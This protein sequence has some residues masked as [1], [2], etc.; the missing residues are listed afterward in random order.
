MYKYL[1]MVRLGGNLVKTALFADSPLHALLLLKYQFGMRSVVT[2]PMRFEGIAEGYTL[3]DDLV[4]STKPLTV[5][6]QRLQSLQMQ[7]DNITKQIKAER[8]RQKIAT[9]QQQIYTATHH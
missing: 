4:K 2:S 7:K 9:A 8:D 3:L 5:K 6:Q 1:A